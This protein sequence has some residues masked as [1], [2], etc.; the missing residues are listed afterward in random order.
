MLVILPTSILPAAV[1]STPQLTIVASIPTCCGHGQAFNAGECLGRESIGVAVSH[2]GWRGPWRLLVRDAVLRNADGSP[3]TSEDPFI[4]RSRRG[5]HL[6][7]H[8][9][10][11]TPMGKKRVSSYAYSEVGRAGARRLVPS[12]PLHCFS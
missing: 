1:K 9:Y 10:G 12:P 8:S 2:G 4:W 6:L 5:W 11:H 3:Y 7:T